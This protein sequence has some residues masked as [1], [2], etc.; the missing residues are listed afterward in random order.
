MKKLLALLLCL[1]LVLALAACGEEPAPTEAPTAA[2]TTEPT[3]EPTEPPITVE[4]VYAD[5]AEAMKENEATAMRMELS[6]GVSYEEGKGENAT[7]TEVDYDMLMDIKISKDPFNCY[8]LTSIG[9][10]T[11]GFDMDIAVEMYMVEEDGNVVI[12]AYAFDSWSRQDTGMTAE[13]Y[14]S[15]ENATGIETEDIWTGGEMPADMTLDE[16]TQ[17]LDGTEVYILRG[18]AV[19]PNLTDALTEMGVGL[20]EDLGEISLPVVYYVDTQNYTI[21]RMVA[22]MQGF[23]DILADSMSES[24]LGEDAE[25][26]GLKIEISDAIYDLGYGAQ[27]IPAL[28][29]E[30]LDQTSQEE[31]EVPTTEAVPVEGAA[32]DLGNGKF[33]LPCGDQTVTITCPEGWSGEIYDVNNVWIYNDDGSIYGDYFYWEGWT[34]D[35]ILEYWIQPDVD[36]LTSEATFVSQGDGPAIEGYITKV[37]IG[38]ELSFYYAFAPVGDGYFLLQVYDWDAGNDAATLLPQLLDLITIE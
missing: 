20:S 9:F 15:S 8:S 13:E 35:D 18:S 32:A 31:T 11:T 24:I 22:D 28:P 36:T 34:A 25:T 16:F 2:P 5:V 3:T 10:E 12:Y 38:T 4:D 17:N 27:E 30:A 29:Q 33:S 23:M 14:L 26:T 6:F 37:V 7:T 21:V 19:I 1:S